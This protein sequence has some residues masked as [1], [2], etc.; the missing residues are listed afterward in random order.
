MP[1]KF[2]E[3]VIGSNE[4]DAHMRKAFLVIA[5]AASLVAASSALAA[6]IDSSGH[7]FVGKGRGSTKI[8]LQ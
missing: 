8:K 6:N 3:R 1:R 2:C 4:G 5:T 7:G